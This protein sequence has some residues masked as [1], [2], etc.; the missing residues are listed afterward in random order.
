M[1]ILSSRTSLVHFVN[2]TGT[3]HSRLERQSPVCVMKHL[4]RHID[5]LMGG[6][7][8]LGSLFRT[9]RKS[10]HMEEVFSHAILLCTVQHVLL[11][12][13]VARKQFTD[14]LFS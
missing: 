7:N 9:L 5:A 6:R 3:A 1:G 12:Q 11:R 4:Q 2:A 13:K 8:Q 10:T 14:P